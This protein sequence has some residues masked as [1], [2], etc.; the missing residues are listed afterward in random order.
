M[1]GIV[2]KGTTILTATPFAFALK[3]KCRTTHCDN[4]FKSHCQKESWRI[5]RAECAG[6]KKILPQVLPDDARFIARVI[7]KLNQGGAD[8]LGYYTETNFRKFDDLMSHYSDIRF[9]PERLEHAIDLREILLLGFL[10]ETLVPEVPDMT[11]WVD[12]YGKAF[13]NSYSI[14]DR[15]MESIGTG[16]YLGASIIDHSCKPNAI[17][18]FEGTMII[19]RTLTDLPSL[20]WSQVS[21]SYVELLDSTESRRQKLHEMHYFWCN[22]E[23]CEQ[24]D[25]MVEAAACPNSSCDSP[26]S[27]KAD[28]C[29]N[30]NA[31]ISVEFKK[32]FE[33][34]VDLT[35]NY[36]KYLKEGDDDLNNWSI[37]KMC[38][39]KQKGVMHRFNIQHINTLNLARAIAINLE[40]WD[41]AEIYNKEL[42]PGY[43][44]YHGEIYLETGLLYLE[45]GNI[46][47]K[48]KKPKE[49]LE[50]LNKAKMVL[51]ITH[52]DEHPLVREE[53]K[54]LLNE[55]IESNNDTQS[56]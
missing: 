1:S 27:I 35:A 18:T 30:C 36:L 29:G 46:Q 14:Q 10:D 25:I 8:E 51:T 6:L 21:I 5:H 31:Q 53:L 28:K 48:L 4:C 41:Y 3:S 7:I 40:C 20:D 26:C 33:Q 42:L 15:E 43:S 50:T 11:K 49:A 16:L 56:P 37:I 55:A 38:L 24:E 52:G 34:V 2:K 32:T 12:I 22:C 23:R 13:I 39:E 17:V 47:L 44:L 19:I 45:T 9:D 54:L